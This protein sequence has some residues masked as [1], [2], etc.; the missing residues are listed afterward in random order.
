VVVVVV[1]LVV[2]VVLVG[3]GV[4]LVVVVLVVGAEVVVLV[5]VLVVGAEVVV[6]VVV[7]VVVVVGSESVEAVPYTSS[8]S[9]VVNTFTPPICS[10]QNM[11]KPKLFN[12][13]SNPCGLSNVPS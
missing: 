1:E 11:P 6:L 4:V 9:V 5:V 12:A 10:T 7:L 8:S 2:V 13:G 3:I